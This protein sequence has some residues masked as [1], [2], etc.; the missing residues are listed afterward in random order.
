MFDAILLRAFSAIQNSTQVIKL[1][2]L[3]ATFLFVLFWLPSSI[4]TP[5]GLVEKSHQWHPAF[6]S[7]FDLLIAICLIT[8]Y[9]TG[10]LQ[11][12]IND[13]LAFAGG[14]FIS[15]I[16]WTLS[17]ADI[18]IPLV[19]DIFTHWLRLFFSYTVMKFVTLHARDEHVVA[20]WSAIA[21]SLCITSLAVA[22]LTYQNQ[23]RLWA[24]GM[25]IASFSDFLAATILL[26]FVHRKWVLV[27]FFTVFLLLTLGRTAILALLLVLCVYVVL[28]RKDSIKLIL[29]LILISLAS[30]FAGAQFYKHSDLFASAIDSA[31]NIDSIATLDSRTNIWNY[32]HQLWKDN[33]TPW[34]GVGLFGTPQLL[35]NL[36]VIG[37]DDEIFNPVHFH[38]I[39]LELY[40]GGGW[41]GLLI[42]AF[43][44][45]RLCSS[46]IYRASLASLIY[47]LFFAMNITDFSLYLPKDELALGIVFG[48]AEALITMS[49][50][51]PIL[52][53]A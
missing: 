49:R 13:L 39:I 37:V 53:D 16:T 34:H 31:F 4:L 18:T 8:E 45:L 32:A 15:L 50:V 52:V 5:E 1:L 47:V 46:L 27:A 20:Y 41:L 10:R 33:S 17:D 25:S 30:Y 2:P 40:F 36:Y 9:S 14:I 44:I 28:R 19:V 42:F 43:L 3:S 7:I 22:T 21:I 35:G 6:A 48:Y 38:S 24:S 12:S 51:R 11:S 23:P 29:I 26:L